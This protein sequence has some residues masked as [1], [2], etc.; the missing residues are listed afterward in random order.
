[1]K[2]KTIVLGV[3]SIFILSVS[4]LAQ[5]TPAQRAEIEKTLT[6]TQKELNAS[7]VQLRADVV[8]KYVSEDF[9]DSV[10]GGNVY[11]SSGKEAYLKMLANAF[12]QRTSQKFEMD[13]LKVYVISPDSAYVFMTGGI[14][15][16]MKSGRHGGFGWAGT[17]IWK[18]EP[19]GWKIVHVHESTW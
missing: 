8:A 19:G 5:V 2:S 12:S 16:T 18:K 9:Q 14:S 7:F 10:G 1:M 11:S 17:F 3:F 4:L 6:E 13:S 15:V